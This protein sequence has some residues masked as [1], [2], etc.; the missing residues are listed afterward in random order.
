[1]RILF[2]GDVVGKTGRLALRRVLPALRT[3]LEVDLVIVNGENAA[4]GAG[5]TPETAE[6]L[7]AAGADVLTLG[8]HTWDQKSLLSYL[9]ESP[10]IVRPLNLP[11]GLPGRGWLTVDTPAGRVGVLNLI[12]R[13]FLPILSDDPF[14]AADEAV[15]RIRERTPVIITDFHAEATSE[16]QALGWYLDGR[17]TAVVGTHTH[18]QTADGRILP[19]GTAYLSDVGMTGAR[20][21]VIGID[22]EAIIRR[23][24]TQ[25]PIRF[26]P[27]RGDAIVSAVLIRCDPETGACLEVNA[28]TE[29]VSNLAD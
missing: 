20:D 17:V 23:F 14:R 4:G 7:L 22:R 1:M 11:P 15:A 9:D 2:V 16:K 28:F 26:E 6:E 10:N 5:L 27:A 29:L 21:S 13:V 19:G 12:G 24:L 3:R 25:Q 8:N 18:V